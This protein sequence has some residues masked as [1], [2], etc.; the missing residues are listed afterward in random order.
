[1]KWLIASDLHGSFAACRTLIASF[2][3][4]GA[5]RMLLLGDLLYHGPRNPL[6]EEYDPQAV[7]ALLNEYADSIVAVRGNCDAEVDQLLLS[8]PILSDYAVLSVGKRLFYATHGHKPFPA[9]C[10]GDAL[11][12]GHI[13][14]PVMEER[15]GILHLNPGSIAL[16]KDG[17]RA[18]Y[19]LL[20]EHS[21]RQVCLDGTEG[22]VLPL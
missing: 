2:L 15:E 16:P 18:G 7:A 8:F 20:E 4:E 5:D 19:L 12:Y 14:T 10:V 17:T 6:P 22:T 9:L 21:V 13:H 3:T 11:L 1:M